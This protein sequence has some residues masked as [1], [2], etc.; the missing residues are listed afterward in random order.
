MLHERIPGKQNIRAQFALL[1]GKPDTGFR[2]APPGGQLLPT[3]ETLGGWTAARV[4]ITPPVD[5]VNFG[6]L[7]AEFVQP[8]KCCSLIVRARTKT[9]P[10]N[11]MD[12]PAGN[13]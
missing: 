4:V 8:R 5:L 2:A 12:A 11:A 13:G 1:A 6:T 10:S 3:F 9:P 7:N